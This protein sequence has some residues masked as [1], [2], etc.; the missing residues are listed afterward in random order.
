MSTTGRAVSKAPYT[1]SWGYSR[2]I[3]VGDRVEVSGTSAT[4]PDG[5][6]HAPG[7]PYEQARFV[8]EII[9]AAL[10]DVGAS[11]DDVVR[12]RAYL[13]RIDDWREVG[14]AHLEAFG[15]IQ[16]ASTCV[17]GIELMAPELLVE[18]EAV[19]VVG[20]GRPA[21]ASGSL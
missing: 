12:T 20:A 16:P 8:L 17:A 14:R 19:A 11:M 21:D 7:D 15:S 2:A 3:R 18:L 6:V 1:S 4:N 5:A 10:E 9:R 13:T